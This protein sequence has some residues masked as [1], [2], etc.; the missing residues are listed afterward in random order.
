MVSGGSLNG[1]AGAM[2]AYYDGRLLTINFKELP[3]G[4]EDANLRHNG[5]IN[6]I[7]Q[8]DGCMPGGNMFVSVLD[9]I[10]GDGFNPLWQ[11]VQVIFTPASGCKQFFSDTAI[12]DA[13]DAHQVTLRTTTEL[14]RCSVV[15]KP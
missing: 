12:L 7:Y 8:S 13:R 5:S 10:Q 3:P 11:E 9:A 15:G 4:G 6:T 2:P 1:I 14:Y